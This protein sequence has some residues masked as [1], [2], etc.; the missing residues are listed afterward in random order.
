M[1]PLQAARAH[2]AKARE[3]LE[4]AD[5]ELSG[6]LYNGATSSA[7][8]AGINAKDAICLRITGRTGK[9]DN[10]SAAIGELARAGNAGKN[11]E[12]TFRRLLGMKTASQYQ[13]GP[14]GAA[15]ARRAVDWATRM[16]DTADDVVR[17]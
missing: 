12:T 5:V 16:V 15:D 2:L 9:T 10:H 8:I 4:A 6:E 17:T 3:F 7:V 14:V 1:Q 11:L 13:A